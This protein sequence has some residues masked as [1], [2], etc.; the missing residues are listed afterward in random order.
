MVVAFIG[1]CHPEGEPDG[2]VGFMLTQSEI[3]EKAQTT[4]GTPIYNRHQ[5][6]LGAIGRIA[7]SWS[8]NGKLM[9]AG[10]IN[11]NTSLSKKICEGLLNGTIKGLSLGIIHGVLKN[12][13]G[14]CTNI[15]WRDIVDV[16]VCN[17]GDLPGTYITT[18]A[19]KRAVEKAIEDGK[20]DQSCF[21]PFPSFYHREQQQAN[22][23]T[24]THSLATEQ[25]QRRPHHQL[26]TGPFSPCVCVC[27]CVRERKQI[28]PPPHFL[29]VTHVLTAARTL[30]NT[31]ATTTTTMS[32]A[33]VLQQQQAGAG[34][35]SGQASA[36]APQGQKRPRDAY[37]PPNIP[38]GLMNAAR[39]PTT[40]QQT[41][42][43]PAVLA[44]NAALRKEQGLGE[45]TSKKSKVADTTNGPEAAKQQQQNAKGTPEEAPDAGEPVSL[46]KQELVELLKARAERDE[47]QKQMEILRK[48]YKQMQ[49]K[50]KEWHDGARLIF[51]ANADAATLRAQFNR[52]NQERCK[53]AREKVKEA[54]KTGKEV[55]KLL[56][57]A[58]KTPSTG[59]VDGLQRLEHFYKNP[60]QLLKKRCRDDVLNLVGLLG[61]YNQARVVTVASKNKTEAQL[62]ADLQTTQA[63]YKELSDKHELKKIA[64]GG[65]CPPTTTDAGRMA[66]QQQ[67]QQRLPPVPSGKTG[68]G[69]S[70]GWTF[71]DQQDS[72][73]YQQQKDCWTN[74][75][76]FQQTQEVMTTASSGGGKDRF[77]A[78]YANSASSVPMSK[79]DPG[80][81]LQR[82]PQTV[83]A[84]ILPF[85]TS[86]Q[87]PVGDQTAEYERRLRERLK[88]S[89][90]QGRLNI[91]TFVGK[92]YGTGSD[93]PDIWRSDD[94]F[95]FGRGKPLM[96]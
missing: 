67:Q 94:Q 95:T 93:L 72:Q 49:D 83:G 10:V 23:L 89:S 41:M 71:S 90:G 66:Q 74:S 86:Y 27:V 70:H 85:D 9:V 42:I 34:A 7:K 18:V 38:Q 45:P 35:P 2:S 13:S 28:S 52:E 80:P 73:P 5:H 20:T 61:D 21:S 75:Q 8:E 22:D 57:N 14:K 87:M 37:P 82:P 79:I 91:P 1:C 62:E 12:N 24:K 48:E 96:E 68:S 55:K 19:A 33:P 84:P 47:N 3:F 46:T 81:P 44:A 60:D 6:H 32:D 69:Y 63:R 53:M 77:S 50:N 25:Q 43:D 54:L 36:D 40:M 64:D 59:L 26:T 31:N 39:P 16:S 30:P 17:E 4:A 58:G 78:F 88:F 92:Q 15:L 51:G 29:L 76:S 56:Q 65:Q 11:G